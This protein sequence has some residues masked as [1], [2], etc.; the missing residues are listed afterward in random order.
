MRVLPLWPYHFSNVPPPLITLEVSVSTYE[1]G[2]AVGMEGD[3]NV[4][5]IGMDIYQNIYSDFLWVV[6]FWLVGLFLFT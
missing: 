2:P 6:E 3:V 5:S 4:P 1:L